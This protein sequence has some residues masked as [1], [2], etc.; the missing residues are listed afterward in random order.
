VRVGDQVVA[1]VGKDTV[2]RYN[3][4]RNGMHFSAMENAG[5]VSSFKGGGMSD[6]LKLSEKTVSMQHAYRISQPVRPGTDWRTLPPDA[7][8]RR[9]GRN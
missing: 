2:Y 4:G 8:S 6:A 9:A 7:L 3:L 1:R 5:T